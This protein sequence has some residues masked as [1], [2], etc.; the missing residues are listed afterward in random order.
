MENLHTGL[1]LSPLQLIAK[2]FEERPAQPHQF[3]L[4]G[5]ALAQDLVVLL[6]WQSD[7]SVDTQE[8]LLFSGF[9]S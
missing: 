2:H 5:C 9:D 4:M 3:H 8:G 6:Y 1:A 7:L